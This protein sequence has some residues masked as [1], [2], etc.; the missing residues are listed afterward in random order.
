[1]TSTAPS[2]I[3]IRSAR[4]E[5]FSGLWRVASLDD[6]VVPEGPLLVAESDGELIAALSLL[7]GDA[8]A[9][10]FLPTRP[11]VDLLRLRASQLSRQSGRAR[12][13]L[14]SRLRGQR[15]ATLAAQ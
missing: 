15:P 13:G 5:D 8:V 14:L 9:D 1:M 2:Y 3:S 7:T 11:A 4:H 12:Q 6:A 10:P